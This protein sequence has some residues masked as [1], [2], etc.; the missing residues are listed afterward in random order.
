MK[1]KKPVGNS[2]NKMNKKH[3][4]IASILLITLFVTTA[5]E[6]EPEK[7][8]KIEWVHIQT[9]EGKTS[10][11]SPNS[12]LFKEINL[13]TF[14]GKG[15]EENP[16]IL[17]KI[18]SEQLLL[19]HK[20]IVKFIAKKTDPEKLKQYLQALDI[21]DLNDLI[22]ACKLLGVKKLIE[23]MELIHIKTSDFDT[24]NVMFTVPKSSMLFDQS[25][26]FEPM[27]EGKFKEQGT[28]KNPISFQDIDS[29]QFKF[30][31]K[32][33]ARKINPRKLKQ[34]LQSLDI[35]DLNN[36]IGLGSFLDT[37]GL[38]K[39]VAPYLSRQLQNPKALDTWLQDWVN[40]E[41]IENKNLSKHVKH[42]LEN[43]IKPTPQYL[44]RKQ[45]I[46]SNVLKGHTNFVYPV[47]FSPDGKILAS[48][49]QT[50]VILWD[51]KT[52]ALIHTLT[53]YA[54]LFTSI[55]FS[56]DG[57]ILAAGSMDNTVILWDVKKGAKIHILT[58]HTKGVTAV[59]FS[60]DGTTLASSSYDNTIIL[61][62]VKKGAKIHILTGH[63]KDVTAFAFSPDGTTLASGS[64]GE[65]IILWDVKKG[66]KI[67][68]L[69]G[70]ENRVNSVAFS[71]DGTILASG[72]WD[73]TIRLWNV[74][75]GALIHTLT[76]HTKTVVSVVFSPD[77][78]TLASGSADK[79]A[80]LWHLIDLQ[81]IAQLST[82]ELLLIYAWQ[83]A[84]TIDLT[85]YQKLKTIYD[86][87]SNLAKTLMQ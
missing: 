59:A 74:K 46:L 21:D 61:W 45:P 58:G 75:K 10:V 13:S 2:M 27:L 85:T 62:D 83:H 35:D 11:F 57:K 76:R 55:A 39:S 8:Q 33:I 31:Y 81:D 28:E 30:I 77:G 86:Q 5:M 64:W 68:I 48:K 47:E 66:A 73:K 82:L 69:T 18:T 26:F 52:G 50:D 15:T 41:F 80:I 12:S 22:E 70:H 34:F 16:I 72:S 36:L 6:V 4:L 63:T 87:A 60:P 20:F 14:K 25:T 3:C 17:K 71:P 44:K 7:Q 49:S 43:K 38:F 19:I 40:K 23:S 65:T 53:E 32:F 51:V 29:E 78:T 37:K 79:T 9:S 56:P 1:I 24:I 84:G 67:H 54:K 42:Y